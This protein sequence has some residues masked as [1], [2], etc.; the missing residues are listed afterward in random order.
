MRRAGRAA[1]AT[2]DGRLRRA[3]VRRGHPRRPTPPPLPH[4]TPAPARLRYEPL[5]IAE[6][7]FRLRQI[8]LKPPRLE[9]AWAVSYS[10][11]VHASR[12]LL[13]HW[14]SDQ[15][16][17]STYSCLYSFILKIKCEAAK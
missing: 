7:F 10:Q 4:P 6:R 11:D 9:R 3:R 12:T 14:F 2:V 8:R 17:F 15:R 1:A 5:V 13:H 16:F